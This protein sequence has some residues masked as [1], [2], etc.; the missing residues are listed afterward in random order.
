MHRNREFVY[1]P[2]VVFLPASQYI[3][4]QPV[5]AL[6]FAN[7][8]MSSR[9]IKNL[10]FLI[11]QSQKKSNVSLKRESLFSLLIANKVR[12][13]CLLTTLCKPKPPLPERPNKPRSFQTF[14]NLTSLLK[15][16]P[17]L[18]HACTLHPNTDGARPR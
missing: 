12:F 2:V 13:S 17:C 1:P 18:Y 6:Y 3:F 10:L 16:L 11:G 14:I 7:Q 4:K 5:T 8:S 15:P 9:F